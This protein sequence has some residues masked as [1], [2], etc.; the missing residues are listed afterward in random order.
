MGLWSL[1]LQTEKLVL[2]SVWKVAAVILIC[3]V[4]RSRPSPFW[5]VG[6]FH[7]EVWLSLALGMCDLLRK[8]GAFDEILNSF[9]GC[10]EN[11]ELERMYFQVEC[12]LWW[13]NLTGPWLYFKFRGP[14]L[15]KTE[16]R[17]QGMILFFPFSN[18]EKAK[19]GGASE[20]WYKKTEFSLRTKHLIIQRTIFCTFFFA[21]M[22]GVLNAPPHPP[23]RPRPT[24]RKQNLWELHLL[25]PLQTPFT[26]RW[27]WRREWCS[28]ELCLLSLPPSSSP[29]CGKCWGPL[30][31]ETP[32][33]NGLRV[34]G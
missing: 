22:S 23:T 24:A 6:P 10:G 25:F 5:R 33:V 2:I 12:R 4:L 17:K 14:S 15:T 11:Y 29:Q 18:Q 34:N 32:F 28:P 1:C 9:Q 27:G 16:S 26:G 8:S 31:Y 19:S 20:I 13:E 3:V 21:T 30:L 7:W